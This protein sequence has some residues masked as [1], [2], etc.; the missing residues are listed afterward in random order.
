MNTVK[1]DRTV[2]KNGVSN[3]IEIEISDE[4][5]K[6]KLLDQLQSV[7]KTVKKK[8]NTTF[9]VVEK[10]NDFPEISAQ[11]KFTDGVLDKRNLELKELKNIVSEISDRSIRKKSNFYLRRMARSINNNPN[12][13]V[14]RKEL[15]A[16]IQADLTLR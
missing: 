6:N 14:Y 10:L 8:E 12:Y 2:E 7:I 9:E 15:M 3:N 5:S 4:E 16:L 13:K 1:V 11:F